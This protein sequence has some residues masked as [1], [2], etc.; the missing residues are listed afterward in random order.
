MQDGIRKA[1]RLLAVLSPDYTQSGFGS[2]EWAA[3]V[4]QDPTGK[5]RRLIAVRVRRC[6][7]RGLLAAVIYIDLV[8]KEE[9]AARHALLDGIKARRRK[10]TK[11]P[12]ISGIVATLPDPRTR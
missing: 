5:H 11:P 6:D 8:G 9:E 3:A 12:P 10:P 7:A 2:A 1:Q 4:A